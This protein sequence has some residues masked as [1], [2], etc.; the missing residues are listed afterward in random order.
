MRI[1]SADSAAP[2]NF[3]YIDT[4]TYVLCEAEYYPLM[5]KTSYTYK[6]KNKNHKKKKLVM[7]NSE[8]DLRKT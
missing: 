3:G 8:K 4:R 5:I 7:L 6:N 1:F 2:I